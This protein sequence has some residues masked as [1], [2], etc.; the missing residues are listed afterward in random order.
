M[1]DLTA[2]Q[3]KLETLGGLAAG[4]EQNGVA[5]GGA[6]ELL[7]GGLLNG[8]TA[9]GAGAAAGGAEG[10]EAGGAHLQEPQEQRGA[11][12]PQARQQ[13]VKARVCE[14]RQEK[15]QTKIEIKQRGQT[16]CVLRACRTP[17]RN[18]D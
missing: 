6:G 18:R 3:T 17:I 13:Q 15:N 14:Q 4:L 9:A 10:M 11:A 1:A 8:R 16:S 2:L 7:H 12:T 5:V